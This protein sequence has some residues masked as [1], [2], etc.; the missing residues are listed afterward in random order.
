M[1]N[2]GE[3]MNLDGGLGE[4][5]K[6]EVKVE[7]KVNIGGNE[8]IANK[9]ADKQPVTNNVYNPYAPKIEPSN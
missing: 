4:N 7:T 9:V 2:I 6:V 8:F 3:K 1:A 5:K